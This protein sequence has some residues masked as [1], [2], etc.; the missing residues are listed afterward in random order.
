MASVS[1]DPGSSSTPPPKPVTD[2]AKNPVVLETDIGNAQVQQEALLRAWVDI[3]PYSVEAALAGEREMETFGN[4]HCLFFAAILWRHP[5]PPPPPP[6]D[7]DLP[8]EDFYEGA[9]H[10]YPFEFDPNEVALPPPSTEQV[11]DTVGLLYV[12]S[13]FS[14]PGQVHI[15]ADVL[16]PFRGKGIGRRACDTAVAWALDILQMHRV[17]ARIFGGSPDQH[18]VRSLFAA[19]GF[20]YEGVHRRAVASASGEWADVAH[21]GVLDTDWQ[22]RTR[23]GVPPRATL[24]DELLARHQREREEMLRAEEA[25]RSRPRRSSSME[26]I[27]VWQDP[28]D[29]ARRRR[30]AADRPLSPMSSA[31]SRSSSRSPS[32][33]ST[34]ESEWE[35]ADDADFGGRERTAG[36][37]SAGSDRRHSPVLHD[38]DWEGSSASRSSSVAPPPSSASSSYGSVGSAPEHSPGPEHRDESWDEDWVDF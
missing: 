26:T 4:N 11:W 28:E 10:E 14:L 36:P 19:L 35:S 21:M 34:S 37:S 13:A 3:L 2:F 16:P 38:S 25:L 7:G 6:T 30:A 24:W 5:K 8:L 12:S 32:R 27:R 22:I 33:A 9:Q 17:Q 29:S 15:G 20:A 31:T 1:F 23:L 18:R